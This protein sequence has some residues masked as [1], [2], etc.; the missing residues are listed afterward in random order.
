MQ[1]E[2][3][4]NEPNIPSTRACK[5]QKRPQNYNTK[6]YDD[7]RR[8][9][10]ELQRILLNGIAKNSQPHNS[11]LHPFGHILLLCVR[12]ACKLMHASEWRL[13]KKIQ[14]ANS[15]NGN[16]VKSAK[17]ALNTVGIFF[18]SKKLRGL[19]KYGCIKVF[20]EEGFFEVIFS[21]KRWGNEDNNI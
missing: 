16:V 19:L 5:V 1:N 3:Q 8:Y 17:E 20:N 2:I 10:S 7:E 18:L 15:C 11:Y 14:P 9:M 21:L 12:S 4:A 6:K 13:P